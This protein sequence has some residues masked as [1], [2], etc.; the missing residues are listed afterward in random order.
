VIRNTSPPTNQAFVVALTG[1]IASG[2]TLIS[3]EFARLGVPVIDTDVIAH[4]IV[5]PGKSGLLEIEQVFGAQVLDVSG[6]LRRSELRALIFSDSDARR[7]LEAILH[8]IIR[9]EVSKSISEVTSAY[10]ILVIPLLAGRGNYPD[11]D[12]VL[13]VDVAP[14]VQIDRLMARDNCSREQAELALESQASR[15]DR[16][17]IADDVL[18]N[19]GAPERAISE[20]A[21]FHEKYGGMVRDLLRMY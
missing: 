13:V 17:K 4:E 11:V 1:G 10:C 6:G 15:E 21:R 18:D 7:K 3:D 5:E 16:L 12:R 2:K 20:V 8:P 9:Q 19:S 14:D